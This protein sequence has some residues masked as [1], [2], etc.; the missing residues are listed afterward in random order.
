MGLF[1]VNRIREAINRGYH[2][3]ISLL[4]VILAI[5][6]LATGIFGLV[7]SGIFSSKAN[8]EA[9][10]ITIATNLLQ[11]RIE[12]FKSYDSDNPNLTAG[13]HNDPD[14]PV[15]GKYTVTWDVLD[16]IPMANC[17]QIKVTAGWKKNSGKVRDK[18]V[19]LITVISF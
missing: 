12:C 15:E 14:N 5:G 8:Y 4:E 6:V 13:L 3:G 1:G 18:M 19:T 17:K 9:Q 2:R 11:S 16:D 10:E 7:Q